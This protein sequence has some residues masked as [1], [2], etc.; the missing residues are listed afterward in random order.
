MMLLNMIYV[1]DFMIKIVVDSIL[2]NKKL[3]FDIQ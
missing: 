3:Y 1:T 2:E